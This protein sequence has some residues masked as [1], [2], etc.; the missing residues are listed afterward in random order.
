MLSSSE[1]WV[2][3]WQPLLQGHQEVFTSLLKGATRGVEDG[4]RLGWCYIHLLTGPNSN[5]NKKYRATNLNN[6]LKASWKRVLYLTIYR[7]N[8]RETSRKSGDQ[9]GLAL[10]LQVGGGCDSKGIYQLQR[11]PLRTLGSQLHAGIPSPE[12]PARMRC[13]YITSGCENQ[14]GFCLPGRGR[15]WLKTQTPS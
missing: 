2:E 7:R 10:L 15:S 1:M 9:K 12:H 4:D 6:Q 3:H 8:H 5:Y 14:Q 13:T 11:F